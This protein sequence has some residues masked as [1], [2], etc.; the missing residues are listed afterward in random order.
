MDLELIETGDG[1]DLIKS[2]K[3]LSVIFGFENFVY[4]AM[5]GGNIEA[6]TPTT[7]IA[8]E[9][10]FDF[11]ANNL[12]MQGDDSIQF[13]S[14]TERI[15][16]SVPLTSSS[17]SLIQQAVEK[18]LAFMKD[19]AIVTIIVQI[20]ATDKLLIACRILQPDNLQTQD[21]IF[22]WDATRQ[23]LIDREV[24]ATSRQNITIRYFDSSFDFSFE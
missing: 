20:I 19:F 22:L 2:S 18:D 12:L 3:D 1:G 14:Q 6:S 21:F 24:I 11:W 16:K 9:Q 8:S 13:N 5:F 7:R 15:L 10:A 17:R 4:L 23:E